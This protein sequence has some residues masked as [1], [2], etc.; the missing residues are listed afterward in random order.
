MCLNP[1]PIKTPSGKIRYVP[2]GHCLQCLK[3]YQDSW[4]A[5]LNEE[6]KQWKV[7]DGHKPCI[8]FTLDYRPES[9]PNTYL[10]VTTFGVRISNNKPSCK[11]Y[12]FWT[13]TTHE[14]RS[15][16]L[17]RR[18][19]LLSLYWQYVNLSWSLQDKEASLSDKLKGYYKACH[20]I[21]LPYRYK[22]DTPDLPEFIVDF[23]RFSAGS[24]EHPRG[25]SSHVLMD[26]SN[27][28]CQDIFALEFHSVCY[29]DV[30]YWL[31]R[32]RRRLQYNKPNIYDQ[33][34]NPYLISDWS[35]QSGD[36]FPLPSASLT[37]TF[38][39][40]ITSEYGPK[41]FRPHYHGVIFGVTYE[42]F[43]KYFVPDWNMRFGRVDFSLLRPSGGAMLY[44]A[45]Y[46]A[47]GEYEHPYC[48]RDY[49]YNDAEY[50][51]RHYEDSIL[52]FGLDLPLVRPTFHLMSK[53]IGLFYCFNKEIQDY[54]SIP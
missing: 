36:V 14:R 37:P 1:R 17:R 15:A 39:Y 10:I 27:D 35:D 54:F 52:D 40:F 42:D 50:H 3:A 53:G 47:K 30:K 22:F 6:L 51:S 31:K 9:I 32:S 24:I 34:V 19:H 5:R 45:K 12:P 8:F 2:C 16:W 44:V 38:K 49:F 28:G 21:Y 25:D 18:K 13:D 33:D 26:Y 29:D 23:F 4:C 7:V 20:D 41:T 48:K 46:C 11:I 43:K